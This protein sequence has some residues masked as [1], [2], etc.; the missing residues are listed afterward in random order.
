MKKKILKGQKRY[1]TAKKIFPG[2]N[3]FL[4]K[5]PDQFL[6][7]GWPVYFSRAKGC[8]VWDLDNRKFFDMSLMGVGTNIL[9]YCNRKVDSAVEKIIKKGNISTLNCEEDIFLS[10]KL[11][12][13]HPWAN[14]VKLA[15]TGGEANSIAI[16]IA[17]A[18]SGKDNVAFCGYHG[19]H[20]W[21]L[22][23]NLQTN[24][25]LDSHLL[26]N[27]PIKGVPKNLKD[28]VFPFKYNNY[29]QLERLVNRNNIGVI[30]M[31]VMR[32]EE[33]RNNFLKK[34][35]ALA[36]KKNIVLIFDEC[37]SGFRK[38]YGGLHKL[39]KVN[40]DIAL[41]GKALGNGYPITA[42]IGKREVMECAENTF[43]SSTFWTERIGP[44]AAISTLKTMKEVKSWKKIDSNGKMI[45]KKWKE[46]AVKYELKISINGLP[47]LCSFIF[48]G[49]NF[50]KYKT[51]ITQEMLKKGFLASNAIYSSIA[52]NKDVLDQ[53]FFELEKI[54]KL[55][56]DCE[57]GL[58]ID[59]LLEYPVSKSGFERLN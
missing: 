6:P 25:N 12:E 51:L 56:Q 2:G 20:D 27:L 8:V 55:I 43:I 14:M 4:S 5:N 52:H 16:R 39:Y 53:Y 19:W 10:E 36:S 9:G 34:V 22:A 17:R 32:N 58:S 46:L 38:T 13:I 11:I 31:E 49:K 45:I 24:K 54:F 48:Q 29:E 7:K 21:Y 41:F 47:A 33:P 28:S 42:I 18:A 35:R 3:M 59:K 40:P 44:T 57:N 1:L 23:T 15:R 50:Q 37:T 26:K 30:C